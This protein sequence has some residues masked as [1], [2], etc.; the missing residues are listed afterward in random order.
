MIL[1]IMNIIH[2]LALLLG[3]PNPEAILSPYSG[4]HFVNTFTY[5]SYITLF[6]FYFIYIIYTFK[7]PT[8]LVINHYLSKSF[9][10]FLYNIPG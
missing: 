2:N 7:C 9:I 6:A 3:N 5:L 10:T 1:L 4:S 8:I